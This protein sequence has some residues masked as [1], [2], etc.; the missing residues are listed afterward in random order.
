MSISSPAPASE[1]RESFIALAVVFHF[2]IRLWGIDLL[3]LMNCTTSC[4]YAQ[5]LLRISPE[6]MR[7]YKRASSEG[8]KKETSIFCAAKN[9]E[10]QGIFMTA[11][12]KQ[13]QQTVMKQRERERI[14]H[15]T[16]LPVLHQAIGYFSH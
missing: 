8:S 9:S 16:Y 15:C 7:M 14:I 4:T 1:A 5:Y 6:D 3:Q 11:R 10:L 2:F 12:I 13:R